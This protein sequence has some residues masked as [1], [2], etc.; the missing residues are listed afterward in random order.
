MEK[1]KI[2]T[3][4]MTP[5]WVDMLSTMFNN[6]DSKNPTLVEATKQEFGR[7]ARAL[8]Q[9]NKFFRD[10]KIF[11]KARIIE[12]HGEFEMDTKLTLVENGQ[13]I[14]WINKTYPDEKTS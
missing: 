11:D 9:Y 4:D 7:M 10:G 2:G 13:F 3:L 1:K 6:M 5:T 8:D 12:L 14:R